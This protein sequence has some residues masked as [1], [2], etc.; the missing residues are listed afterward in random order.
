M[1]RDELDAIKELANVKI[2]EILEALSIEYVSRY[3]YITA[4]CPI[5]G[6]DR[7]D[8]WNWRNEK[9]DWKCFSRGCH[10]S[11]GS[12]IFGLVRGVQNCNFWEAV[13][14]VKTFIDLDLSP[15][16]IQD[17]KDKRENRAFVQSTLR[18]E[19]ALRVFDPSCL[20]KLTYH[21]YL[22][23]RGY[24]RWL[25]S[26]Y[27]IGAC[28]ESGRYMSNRVVIPVLN[29]N[30]D[31]VGFT[32]RTLDTNW[33]DRSI[34]KWKHSS[35]SWV[36]H[37]LFN[38]NNAASH[39][40]ETGTVVLCEG[41]LDVLRLE[42]AGVR[43][44]VA[45]LGKTFYDSQMSI[46]V[47]LNTFTIIDALDN[48]KAGRIGG[49]ALQKAGKILFDVVRAHIPEHRKDVGEMSIEEIRNE[50]KKMVCTVS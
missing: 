39:I 30:N 28:L 26:K 13:N 47:E 37:N 42:E 3:N 15:K 22:E 48:D 10:D 23:K 19:E 9:G 25:V 5:H 1:K 32:G 8:A 18:K 35:G 44:S 4:P 34:P 31:I 38:I 17:L 20:D 43:N 46:L 49:K 16:E 40:K 27:R 21:D 6:G 29:V 24:P 11:L 2:E 7:K 45:I 36:S 12:D 33:Q 14:F 50:F 41:P